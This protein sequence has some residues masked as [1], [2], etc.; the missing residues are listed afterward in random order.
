M[1]VKLARNWSSGYLGK[2]IIG[3]LLAAICGYFSVRGL[4]YFK[5]WWTSTGGVDSTLTVAELLTA[6]VG[7]IGAVATPT[8]SVLVIRRA[9]SAN[10]GTTN[11]EA[12]ERP[13]PLQVVLPALFLAMAIG[14]TAGYVHWNSTRP[15]IPITTS[16]EVFYGKG[17]RDQAQATVVLPGAPPERTHVVFTP[18]LENPSKVGNCAGSAR[19]DVVAKLDGVESTV[20]TDLPHAREIRIALT[21]VTKRAEIMITVHMQ[22]E[23]CTVDLRI[24][25]ATLYNEH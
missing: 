13:A 19:L 15:N 23:A 24:K 6:V 11:N 17:M 12:T 25:K 9:Q 21:G 7:L 10:N 18:V 5:N 2:G 3:V 22:D 4:F 20:H 14:G 16:V 8:T 1:G